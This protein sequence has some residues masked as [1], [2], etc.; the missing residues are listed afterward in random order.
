MDAMAPKR[1]PELK[2]RTF[3]EAQLDSIDRRVDSELVKIAA[4][5]SRKGQG[6]AGKPQRSR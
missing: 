4:R 6:A 3:T 1:W 2:R 5:R